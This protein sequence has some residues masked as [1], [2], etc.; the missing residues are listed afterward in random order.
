VADGVLTEGEAAPLLDGADRLIDRP[1]PQVFGQETITPGRSRCCGLTTSGTA[2]CWGSNPSGPTGDGT[3][4]I[5]WVP[6]PVSGG[7]AFARFAVGVTIR[8]E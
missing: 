1:P 7:H 6:T 2:Y 8:V 3:T 4:A 5:R